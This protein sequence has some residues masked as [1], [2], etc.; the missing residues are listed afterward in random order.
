MEGSSNVDI[1]LQLAAVVLV[2]VHVPQPHSLVAEFTE[3]SAT[4][5]P[6]HMFRVVFSRYLQLAKLALDHELRASVF[7]QRAGLCV[8]VCVGG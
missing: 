2:F 3:V 4:T 8:C 1:F 5:T 6:S 7:L